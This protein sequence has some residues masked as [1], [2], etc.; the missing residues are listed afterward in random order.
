[1]TRNWFVFRSFF[2]ELRAGG[3]VT[4]KSAQVK[5]NQSRLNM[6]QSKLRRRSIELDTHF[7][8]IFDALLQ[9]YILPLY[10]QQWTRFLVL[11]TT[12]R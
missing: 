8:V 1:M 12:A 4:S 11:K 2:L 7:V 3:I 6:F 5:L 9:G 10:T